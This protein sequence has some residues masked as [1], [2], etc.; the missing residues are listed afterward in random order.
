[1]RRLYLQIFV[2]FIG[3]AFL[4]VLP[5]LSRPIS[6]EIP[7]TFYRRIKKPRALSFKIYPCNKPNCGWP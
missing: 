2:A 1:M 6:F 3:I 7:I 4:S 5:P